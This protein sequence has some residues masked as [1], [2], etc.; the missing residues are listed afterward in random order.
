[1]VSTGTNGG[2]SLLE[3]HLPELDTV[4]DLL[5]EADGE[6]DGG[7]EVGPGELGLDEPDEF[8][9][10]AEDDFL[11]EVLEEVVG[12][13]PERGRVPLDEVEGDEEDLVARAE[14]EEGL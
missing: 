12:V 13:D 10:D 4:D 1:M 9:G 6:G 3:T 8:E 2:S 7:E 11:W 14:E 5:A